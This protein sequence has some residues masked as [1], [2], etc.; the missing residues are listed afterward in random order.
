MTFYTIPASFYTGFAFVTFRSSSE[1][2]ESSSESMMDGPR[3]DADDEADWALSS[4]DL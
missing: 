4:D 1:S 3:I 2:Y